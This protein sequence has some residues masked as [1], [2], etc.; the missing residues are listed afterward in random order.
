MRKLLSLCALVT[1]FAVPV[2]A[3]ADPFLTGQFSIGGSVLNDVAHNTLDFQIGTIHVGT[4]TQTG[5]FVTVTPD[6]ALV[7]GSS[8]MLVYSPYCGCFHVTVPSTGFDGLITSIVATNTI[9]GGSLITDFGGT[10]VLTAPGFAPTPGTF[11]F[12]TQDTGIVT[13]S[14]TGI[15]A[16]VPEPSSL[17]LL[18]TGVLGAAGMLRRR[19]IA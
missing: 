7:G 1:A 19:F 9:V 3:H 17:L 13:F 11:A 4:G 8:T 14:A 6:G 10:A 12:S 2:A 18:G 16:P 5:S 15:A